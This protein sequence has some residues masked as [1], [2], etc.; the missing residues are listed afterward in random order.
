MEAPGASPSA[1]GG[2]SGRFVPIDAVRGLIMIL[3]AIDHASFHVA[4]R[5][6]GEFWGVALPEFPDAAWFLTRFV[7]HI[8]A[9]GFFFLMGAGAVFL[10]ASR[11]R[12]GWSDARVTRHL[13]VRGL[14]LIGLQQLL[15]NPT[16]GIGYMAARVELDTYGVV[17][18]GA[19]GMPMLYFGVLFGLG[20]NLALAA[21][22]LRLPTVAVAATG[23]AA[24]LATQ[25][26]TPGA[27]HAATAHPLV[28]RLLMIPGQSG[29]AMV[30]YPVVPWLGLTAAGVVFGRL[31]L[32]DRRRAFRRAAAAGGACLGGFVLVRQ[33]GGFGNFHPPA[34]SGWIAFLNVT[35]Y[36]PSLAFVLLTL[37][38]TLLL[39]GLAEAMGRRRLEVPGP[40]RVFGGTP[41]FFYLAHLYVLLLLGQLFPRG[42]GL[43]ALYVVWLVALLALYPLCRGYAAFRRSKPAESIWRM[44]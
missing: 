2:S 39:L 12:A 14:L 25:L 6:P 42:G 24:V 15:E 44:L 35:K 18:P 9:P 43:A 10:A 27:E 30:L 21:L 38:G 26:L 36:P 4:K 37:G 5:H 16:W 13:I 8:C 1:A 34:D 22:L 17:L 28:A 32:A 3:M 11:R 41:L 20:V 33:A 29:P 23:V 31:L 19:D 7:T 40:L